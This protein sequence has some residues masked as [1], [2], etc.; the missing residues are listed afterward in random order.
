MT[1]DAQDLERILAHL[2]RGQ[3]SKK[4]LTLGQASEGGQ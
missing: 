1:S 3:D 2:A 4:A